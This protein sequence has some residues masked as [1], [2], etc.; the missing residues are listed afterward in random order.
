M[1][2]RLACCKRRG[3]R[4]DLARF[5][6]RG[7]RHPLFAACR[8]RVIHAVSPPLT[9]SP[10]VRFAPIASEVPRRS[11]MTRGLSG[12]LRRAFGEKCIWM[13]RRTALPG[14]KHMEAE[15]RKPIHGII[16]G[17]SVA[18]ALIL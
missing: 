15:M 3:H 9:G 8:L 11:E 7:S 17:A 12:G 1:G 5:V 4:Q 13:P 16:A 18:T 6:D 2:T 14:S 10:H